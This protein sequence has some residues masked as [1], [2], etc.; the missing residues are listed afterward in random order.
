MKVKFISCTTLGMA[1]GLAVT[2]A[3]AEVILADKFE[4]YSLEGIGLPSDGWAIT[5]AEVDTGNYAA[6][7]TLQAVTIKPQQ[8]AN[9]FTTAAVSEHRIG[10]RGRA[11]S[12]IA[13]K[14][15]LERGKNYAIRF[16]NKVS[17]PYS[18]LIVFQ[19]HKRRE[20]NDPTGHQPLQL[21]VRD[22]RWVLS[23]HSNSGRGKRFDLGAID[24]S[25]FTD[26][27]LKIKL[28]SGD[29]GSVQVSRDGQGVLDYRGPNDFRGARGPYVKFGVY[30][31][32]KSCCGGSQTAYYDNVN[33]SSEEEP[34]AAAKRRRN[35]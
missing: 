17:N 15:D 3:Q 12:E 2:A 20:A 35:R 34:P 26:W 16:S 28:S 6:M 33:V 21:H 19:L 4:A 27:E 1:I 24:N 18:N 14:G 31:P 7:H 10:E 22:G 23:I 25:K 30:R 13:L 9:L 29:D 32:G 8:T 5:N 11:R